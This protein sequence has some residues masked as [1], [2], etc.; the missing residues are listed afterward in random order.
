[1]GY[2]QFYWCIREGQNGTVGDVFDIYFVL[3]S[4]IDSDFQHQQAASHKQLKEPMKAVQ[5]GSLSDVAQ[6]AGVVCPLLTG[7]W[8]TYHSHGLVWRMIS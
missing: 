1:M 4:F 3:D 8:P 6:Q 7:Q 5:V 2:S